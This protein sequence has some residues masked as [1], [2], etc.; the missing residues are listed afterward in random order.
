MVCRMVRDGHPDSHGKGAAVSNAT[1][2]CKKMGLRQA[3]WVYQQGFDYL[4]QG[5]N[6]DL[7]GAGLRKHR[8]QGVTC[9]D[10]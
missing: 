3:L 1:A 7:N 10:A 6:K 4:L 8:K 2:G 5:G 9:C